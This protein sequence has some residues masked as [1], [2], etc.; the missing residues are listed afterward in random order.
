MTTV[1]LE[2][3]RQ[4]PA[5]ALRIDQLVAKHAYLSDRWLRDL[6][7]YNRLDSWLIGGRI[8]FSESE[9]LALASYSP[10]AAA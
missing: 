7:Y 9:V 2:P 8:V 3:P 4:I 10:A 1:Q 6:R 5:D